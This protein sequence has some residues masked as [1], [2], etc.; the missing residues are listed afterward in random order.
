MNTPDHQT[1]RTR[2]QVAGEA[3]RRPYAPPRLVDL[4]TLRELT[5]TLNEPTGFDGFLGSG[6]ST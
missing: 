2:P 3:D 4:G 6:I 5:G 1:H